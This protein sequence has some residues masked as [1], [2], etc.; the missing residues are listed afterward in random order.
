MRAGLLTLPLLLAACSSGRVGVLPELV[1]FSAR[2]RSGQI[3]SAMVQLPRP[4]MDPVVYL[5]PGA[6]AIGPGWAHRAALEGGVV[7]LSAPGGTHT[8]PHGDGARI[9][10][11]DQ[12]GVVVED[13]QGIRRLHADGHVEAL[14]AAPVPGGRAEWRGP[15]DGFSLR[16]EGD[17]LSV[18]LPRAEGVGTP[19]VR[20]VE[21]LLGS[22]WLRARDLPDWEQQLLR[23]TFRQIDVFVPEAASARVDGDLREWRSSR[24]VPVDD[25]SQV[26][27][28]PDSWTSDRDASFGVALRIEGG[29]ARMA[30]RIRDDDFVPGGDELLVT[31][32]GRGYRIPVPGRG[33]AMQRGD[34]WRAVGAWRGYSSVVIELAIDAPGA[35]SWEHAPIV[36]SY[37]DADDGEPSATISSAPWPELLSV[38]AASLGR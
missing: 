22:W 28:N 5:A 25:A 35:A 20:D 11:L 27:D 19:I 18:V 34:G 6:A 37:V 30:I 32:D 8:S 1:V 29:E 24:A 26:I 33:A 16:Q 21:A 17:T 23:D 2:T 4:G 10:Q 38:A 3:V 9:L 12:E 31:V 36:V 7:Q 15:F 13:G 14:D